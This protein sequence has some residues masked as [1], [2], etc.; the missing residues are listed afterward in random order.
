MEQES[1][2][3]GDVNSWHDCS[4]YMKHYTYFLPLVV[5]FTA[6]IP[7]L[8]QTLQLQYRYAIYLHPQVAKFTPTSHFLHYF[9][10]CSLS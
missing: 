7:L 9:F 4:T 8:L 3:E 2:L 10:N 6:Q 1:Y 5:R